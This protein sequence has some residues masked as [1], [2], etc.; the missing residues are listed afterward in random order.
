[1][2]DNTRLDPDVRAL[3][4]DAFDRLALLDPERHVRDAIACYSRDAIVD[5]IAI[6]AAKRGRGTLPDGADARYLLGIVQNLHHV[7]E[8]DAITTAL[9]RE[10]LAARDRFLAPLVR[11]R[12]EITA[13]GRTDTID[14]LIGRLVGAERTIDRLFW[15]DASADCLRQIPESDRGPSVQRACRRIHA[16]FRIPRRHRALLERLLLRHLCPLD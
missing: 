14:S 4:D 12:D 7:H 9:M 13:A 3:L 15:A 8:A 11:D 16:A 1:M 2:R 5:A 6:F 10:R